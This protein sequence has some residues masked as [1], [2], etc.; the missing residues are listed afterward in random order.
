M[1]TW[2]ALFSKRVIGI[3]SR[4]Q[5]ANIRT[6]ISS[7]GY[8]VPGIIAGSGWDWSGADLRTSDCSVSLEDM[9]NQFLGHTS[10]VCR[11]FAV[12]TVVSLC[13][14]AEAKIILLRPLVHLWGAWNEIFTPGK[15][16]DGDEGWVFSVFLKLSILKRGSVSIWFIF[17]STFFAYDIVLDY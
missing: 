17:C 5:L 7:F 15:I 16:C 14:I 6:P 1:F 4:E 9:T 11:V 3:L 13:S 2:D 12:T 10:Q 8:L